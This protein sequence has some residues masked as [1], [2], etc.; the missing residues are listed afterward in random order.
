ME[1]TS[2]VLRGATGR[3]TLEAAR[4]TGRGREARRAEAEARQRRGRELQPLKAR[5]REVESDIATA[6]ARAQALSDLMADPDLYKDGDRARDVARERKELE[7]A[8]GGLYGK[9]EELAMRIEHLQTD[10]EA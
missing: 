5:L 2:R 9:W 3:S 4:S 6:E 8:L 1:A 7:E 10:G